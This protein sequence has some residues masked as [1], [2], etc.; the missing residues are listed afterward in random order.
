MSSKINRSNNNEV[1]S[2]NQGYVHR[3]RPEY[4][5]QHNNVFLD[6]LPTTDLMLTYSKS[7]FDALLFNKATKFGETTENDIVVFLSGDINDSGYTPLDLLIEDI[8][9]GTF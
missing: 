3:K 8:D 5:W 6:D 2:P 1:I 9:G 7:E 4:P